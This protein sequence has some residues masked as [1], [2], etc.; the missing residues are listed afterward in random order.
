[1]DKLD[2]SI[3]RCNVPLKRDAYTLGD[4]N[5]FPRS[6]IQQCERYDVQKWLTEQR[7]W[8]I[9]SSY[10]DLRLRVARFALET[11]NDDLRNLKEHYENVQIPLQMEEGIVVRSWNDY[12]RWMSQDRVWADDVFIQA[13][14]WYLELD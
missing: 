9:A 6:I 7:P 2:E 12:W 3:L 10:H 13:T 1:M 14:A 8:K 11:S 4:G 5:C